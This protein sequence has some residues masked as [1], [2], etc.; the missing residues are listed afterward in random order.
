MIVCHCQ[1]VNDRTIREAVRRGAGSPRAVAKACGAGAGC[2]GCRSAVERI[3][4][5]EEK[6]DGES[7]CCDTLQEAGLAE[8]G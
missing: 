5:C 6:Q 1:A 4:E 7:S 8:A 2:G 3:I